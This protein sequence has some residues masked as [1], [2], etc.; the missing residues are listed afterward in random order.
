M[1]TSRTM[2]YAVHAMLQLARADESL[3]V[4]CSQL[5]HEGK[6]PERFLLQ[7]LRNL[8]TRGLLRSTRGVEGGYALN[9]PA[10][11]I[12]LMDVFDAFDNPLIPSIPP[13]EKLPSEV[14]QL[15]HRTLSRATAAARKELAAVTLADLL[16]SETTVQT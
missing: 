9:R 14:C 13:L 7:I 8:V 15:M 6:M 4:P 11:E 10:S 2:A 1:K 3:P 16:H 5:A 12:T